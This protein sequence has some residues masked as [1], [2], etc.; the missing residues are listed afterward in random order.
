MQSICHVSS[1][2]CRCFPYHLPAVCCRLP[3]LPMLHRRCWPPRSPSLPLLLLD[4]RVPLTPNNL[5][6]SSRFALPCLQAN[7]CCRDSIQASGQPW[8]V[9]CGKHCHHRM[10]GSP[11]RKPPNGRSAAS[12]AAT[13]PKLTKASPAAEPPRILQE[14]VDRTLSE[15]AGDARRSRC[16][17]RQL[18]MAPVRRGRGPGGDKG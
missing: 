18:W 14:E 5:T 11:R 1:A 17:A 12:V 16:R 6:R 15:D 4:R 3:S 7:S 9:E 2:V 13:S 10:S 8:R